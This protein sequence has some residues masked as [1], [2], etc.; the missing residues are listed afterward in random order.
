MT[1]PMETIDQATAEQ[2]ATVLAAAPLDLVRKTAGFIAGP[3]A[4]LI[5]WVLPLPALSPE[6]H[7]LAAIGALTVVWWT[8]EAIPLPITALVATVLTVVTGVAT[9]QDAFAQYAS[10]TIFVFLGAFIMGRAIS[11][12]A[13]DRRFAQY[14][15]A[16]PAVSSTRGGRHAAIALLTTAISAWMN[17]TATAAM[18]TPIAV[19]VLSGG[20]SPA[21]WPGS[22]AAM[23]LVVA[24]TS[25]LG[26][27]I[28]PV[29]AAPNLVTM[30]LLQT[31]GGV[32]LSFLAWTMFLAP[33]AIAMT[34]ILVLTAH[35]LFVDEPAPT[36]ARGV[37]DLGVSPT[38]SAGERNCAIVFAVAVTL[39]IMP[40]IVRLL[41]RPDLAGVLD[42]RL[43]EGVVAILAASLLFVLPADWRQRRFTLT[44]RQAS[45]ID[46][47]TILMFG[48]GLALGRLMLTTGLA[49]AIGRTLV[50][51]SGADTL[52]T[53]T[54]MA[55]LV[56]LL[57]T[58]F[59]SNTATTAML[60][61]VFIGI[62][63]ATGVNPVLPAIAVCLGANM[64]FTLPVS[65]PPNAIV[66]GTGLVPIGAMIRYGALLAAI[67][68][69]VIVVG[70][71]LLSPLLSFV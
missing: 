56:P 15:L 20:G 50:Y 53:I 9:A 60:V 17:N 21:R 44:W 38:W 66:Y 39:W 23:M 46:W 12:H 64:S 70:L 65:T 5:V 47:G 32:R 63:Q 69:V 41:D 43:N 3:L 36:S 42:N 45:E 68:F 24:Y 31:M 71:R 29:G 62:C 52:W 22:A 11:E 16:L 59:V 51:Y 40:S 49:E 54:A 37:P 13:L 58:Q 28:T 26:G 55:V 27:L 18:M 19:G 48:G 6:A 61:P 67:G 35:W 8:T 2:R 34:V 7:R 10:P 30:G 1:T 57:I 14:V 25:T 4:L 33:I